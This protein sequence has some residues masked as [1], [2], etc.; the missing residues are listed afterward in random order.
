MLSGMYQE[1]HDTHTQN[2]EHSSVSRL[3]LSLSV[4][5]LSVVRPAEEQCTVRQ[6]SSAIVLC[7]RNSTQCY[8]QRNLRKKTIFSSTWISTINLFIQQK[9]GY[10]PPSLIGFCAVQFFSCF[11][12]V[13]FNVQA[14]LTCICETAH[15]GYHF[16]VFVCVFF[17]SLVV[18]LTNNSGYLQV[19]TK[20]GWYSN[21]RTIYTKMKH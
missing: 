20:A 4:I 13:R 17:W 6:P 9:G 21:E 1:N 11:F 2:G 18:S 15:F 8:A 14:V 10:F 3:C 5:L 16:S 12:L 19:T 7:Y